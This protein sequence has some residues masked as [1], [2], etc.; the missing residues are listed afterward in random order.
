[1]GQ[2]P[3]GSVVETSG[4]SP[5]SER[6]TPSDLDTS[7]GSTKVGDIIEAAPDLKR[8]FRDFP[9]RTASSVAD[10]GTAAP[11]TGKRRIGRPPGSTNKTPQATKNLDGIEKALLAINA[12]LA[13]ATGCPEFQ[14]EESEAKDASGALKVW[15]ET[16]NKVIDPGT[17]ATIN[18]IGT[19]A[20]LE[21]T[22]LMAI[23]NRMKEERKQKVVELPAPKKDEVQVRRES[24][25]N[26]KAAEPG[27]AKRPTDVDPLIYLSSP[28]RD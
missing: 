4:E 23:R 5:E 11:E 1:M 9:F 18:V 26:G 2:K 12:T 13:F 22:R 27:A 8:E 19:F 24:K 7:R 25:P 15:A 17:L 21:G 10:S 6:G 14:W 3:N 28:L 20:W 16:H